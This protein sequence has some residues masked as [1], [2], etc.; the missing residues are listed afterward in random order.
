MK[1]KCRSTLKIE[2]VLI[3]AISDLELLESGTLKNR[4]IETIRYLFDYF[5]HICF[6]HSFGVFL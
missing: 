3:A 1:T 6:V 5:K 2:N 4:H